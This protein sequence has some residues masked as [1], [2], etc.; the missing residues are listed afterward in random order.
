MADD[1]T[2][3]EENRNNTKPLDL[4]DFAENLLRQKG[5]IDLSA[6]TLRQMKLDIVTRLE[7]VTNGVMVANLKDD[8]LKEFESML[9]KDAP[10][11][12]IQGF[13][14]RKIPD[15]DQKLGLA[16]MKFRDIYLG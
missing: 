14:E 15:L 10:P 4:E 6:D 7:K 12:D 1:N 16:Y 8:D 5:L 2:Q 9:D 3:K 13:V 11:E